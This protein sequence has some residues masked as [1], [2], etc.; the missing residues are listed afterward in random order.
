MAYLFPCFI[1]DNSK[2]EEFVFEKKLLAYWFRYIQGADGICLHFFILFDDIKP[3]KFV[4]FEGFERR[5]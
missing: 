4:T 5:W 2:L 3:L 1:H